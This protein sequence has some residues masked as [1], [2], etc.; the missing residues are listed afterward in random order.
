MPYIDAGVVVSYLYLV[1]EDMGLKGCYINPN[2]REEDELRLNFYLDK[3]ANR[4]QIP[5]GAFAVGYE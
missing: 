5:C 3:F 4:H 2:I 1:A